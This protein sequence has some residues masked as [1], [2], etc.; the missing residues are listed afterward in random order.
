[1]VYRNGEAQSQAEGQEGQKEPGPVSR[2]SRLYQV[3]KNK[4]V[5]HPV[6]QVNEKDIPA[7][8]I[9]GLFQGPGYQAAVTGHQ[10]IYRYGHK[11]HGRGIIVYGRILAGKIDFF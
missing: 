4:I 5:G 7:D 1:M 10:K 8:K 6:E 2:Y 9:N 3:I 11:D